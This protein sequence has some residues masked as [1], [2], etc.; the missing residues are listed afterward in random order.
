MSVSQHLDWQ[1]PAVSRVLATTG[2]PPPNSF[3]KT[4]PICKKMG[5]I[6]STWSAALSEICCA[7]THRVAILEERVSDL[8]AMQR[9]SVS[10]GLSTCCVNPGRTSIR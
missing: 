10:L 7:P 1:D 6:V 8:E 2:V 4:I 9:H 3:S 5:S